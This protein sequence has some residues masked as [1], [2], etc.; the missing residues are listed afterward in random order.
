MHASAARVR[1]SAL[2]QGMTAVVPSFND[3]KKLGDAASRVAASTT[4]PPT[5]GSRVVSWWD[6]S[7]ILVPR[8]PSSGHKVFAEK[9]SDEF[10]RSGRGSEEQARACAAARRAA[11]ASRLGSLLAPH[12]QMTGRVQRKRSSPLPAPTLLSC[13]PRRELTSHQ[14]RAP[15]SRAHSRASRSSPATPRSR[16]PGAPTTQPPTHAPF[17]SLRTALGRGRKEVLPR[18]PDG[19]GRG[20][21]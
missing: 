21:L 18:P 20:G 9:E 15:T 16:T 5:N 12:S 4:K 2:K 1:H 3:F 8:P 10:K 19:R 17:N 13:R 7:A 11:L 6:G 14:T